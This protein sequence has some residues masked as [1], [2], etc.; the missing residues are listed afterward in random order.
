MFE[1]ITQQG[2]ASFELCECVNVCVDEEREKG[3]EERERGG[4][5][6]RRRLG[7]AEGGMRVKDSRASRGE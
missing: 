7:R 1:T 2:G 6:G 4:E 3:G 5:G